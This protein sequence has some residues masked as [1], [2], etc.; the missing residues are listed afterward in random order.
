M[1]FT[2]Q[3]IRDVMEVLRP[4][5]CLSREY[6][7]GVPDTDIAFKYSNENYLTVG[8]LRRAYAAMNLLGEMIK[9]PTALNFSIENL[10]ELPRG[11]DKSHELPR[12]PK[13]E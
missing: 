6:A 8:E 12:G 3:E 5:A 11:P 9:S 1:L 13:H 10:K 4:F 7:D 2:D